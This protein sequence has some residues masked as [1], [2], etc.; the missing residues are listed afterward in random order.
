MNTSIAR[1]TLVIALFTTT[2]AVSLMGRQAEAAPL[3]SAQ[4][5][6]AQ[7]MQCHA[8]N[9]RFQLIETVMPPSK[10]TTSEGLRFV[11]PCPPR[12]SHRDGDGHEPDGCG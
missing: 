8:H 6:N 5:L 10:P 12:D 1:S 3:A 4:T 7:A 11:G 2:S 9:S